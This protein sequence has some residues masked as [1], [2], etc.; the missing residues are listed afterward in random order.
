M[1]KMEKENYVM[2]EAGNLNFVWLILENEY[3][4]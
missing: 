2:E 1:D 3:K 4:I